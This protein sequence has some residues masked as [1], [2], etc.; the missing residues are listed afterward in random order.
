MKRIAAT[1]FDGRISAPRSVELLFGDGR[2]RVAL[3]DGERSCLVAALRI[4]DRVG[5]ANPREIE[6][7]DG[8]LAQ[9]APDAEADAWLDAAAHR[10]HGWLRRA[11]GR[12]SHALVALAIGVLAVIAFMRFGIPALA[13][14]A[15]ERVPPSIDRQI[16]ERALRQIDDEWLRPSTLEPARQAEL[17]LAYESRVAPP[18]QGDARHQLEFRGGG[19]VGANA[20]ALPGGIVVVTDELV[21]LAEH[22]DEI[23]IVLAHETGHVTERHTLRQIFESLGITFIFAAL[24]GDLSGPASLAAALP[25]VLMQAGYS[26]R[27]EREADGYAFAWA[28]LHGVPRTRMTDLLKRVEK[29]EGDGEWPP[30]LSTHPSSEERAEHARAK[31]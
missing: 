4:R 1:Y 19:P 27:D 12:W 24:T 28:D 3:P 29:A 30:F 15:A 8:A 25:A 20:L 14:L 21:R 2:V 31:R 6:F 17:R 22:D 16:G 11:E 10:G 13:A 5:A 18:L 9:I 7:P 26:R 23:L